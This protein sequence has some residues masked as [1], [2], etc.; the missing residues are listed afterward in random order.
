MFHV[1]TL[2]SG[3]PFSLLCLWIYFFYFYELVDT[4]GFCQ[5]NL[6]SPVKTQFFTLCFL[7]FRFTE[8]IKRQLSG[9]K[10]VWYSVALVVE[11]NLRKKNKKLFSLGFTLWEKSF[12]E[13]NKKK[14]LKIRRKKVNLVSNK[15]CPPD[16]L[17]TVSHKNKKIMGDKNLAIFQFILAKTFPINTGDKTIQVRLRKWIARKKNPHLTLG[18]IK[19]TYISLTY[20]RLPLKPIEWSTLEK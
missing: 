9:E 16:F 12:A 4:K 6:S 10:K 13:D 11:M 1:Q 8:E 7:P 20:C 2:F 3:D 17:K 14:N 19:Q 5:D 15:K 18:A